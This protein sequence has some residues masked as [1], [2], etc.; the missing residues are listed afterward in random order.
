[1]RRGFTLIEILLVLVILS[2]I[3]GL[4]FTY[5]SRL[6]ASKALESSASLVASVLDQARSLTLNSKNASVYGVHLAE[7]SVTLF[8]GAV[9]DSGSLSNVVSNTH[10]LVG[11]RAITLAGGG[12]E[13]VFSRLSGET[14]NSG[15]LEVFLESDPDNYRVIN[16]ASSGIVDISAE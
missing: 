5:F 14:A 12:D 10:H 11:I 15:S 3:G 9:Y 1:M 16:I 13:V 7:D 2:I 4:T 6:N 8:T